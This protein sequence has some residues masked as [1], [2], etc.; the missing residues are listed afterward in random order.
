MVI[1]VLAIGDICNLI[2]TISKYTKKSKIHLI[3]FPKDGAGV[4]TYADGVELFSSWKVVDQL[5]KINEIKHNYDI[6]LV[7]GTGERIAYLADLNFISYYVGRDIDAPRFIKNSKEQ[8]FNDALHKLNIFERKFYK[9]VF[10]NA[11]AHVAGTWVF[12]HLEKYTKSGIRMDRVPIDTDLF[13]NK[14]ESITREK[15]KFTFFSPQRIGVP[16][17]VDLTWEALRL[18]KSD[19]EIIQVNWFDESTSEELKI[20]EEMLKNVPSQ[21]KLIHMINRVDMAKYYNFA[22]AILGNMK[23]GTFALVELEGVFCGK[24]VIQYTNTEMKIRIDEQD[25]I[26]P[27]L[28]YSNDPKEIAELIDRVVT[29]EKFREELFNKQYDFVKRLSDP[30]LVAKLWDNIFEE[31]VSEHKCITKNTSRIKLKIRL[32]YFLIANRLYIKKIKKIFCNKQIKK[33]I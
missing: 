27:F 5:K 13:N 23:I 19:F 22:D 20:K 25:I 17:G 3:N 11:I 6:C 32:W 14:I 16:K 12:T 9:D 18:C 30:H 31:M 4:F 33:V 8:W 26:P 1:K 24:P 7:T 15:K 21:V 29:S 2:V 10:N 28:P